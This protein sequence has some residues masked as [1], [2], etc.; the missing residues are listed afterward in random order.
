M[1]TGVLSRLFLSF[2]RDKVNNLS[3]KPAPK[4]VQDNLRSHATEVAEQLFN[5]QAVVYICGDADNMAKNVFD[6]FL[7]ITQEYKGVD[8]AEA[9]KEMLKLRENKQYLED[10]WT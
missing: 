4:Y 2:S 9:R 1:S 3:G 6:T 8:I 7:Q 10:I 5:K